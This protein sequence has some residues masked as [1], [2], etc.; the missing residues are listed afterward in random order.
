MERACV[1]AR[2]PDIKP[3]HIYLITLTIIIF[4]PPAA[5]PSTQQEAESSQGM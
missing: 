4:F 5:S 3:V 2:H 1:A